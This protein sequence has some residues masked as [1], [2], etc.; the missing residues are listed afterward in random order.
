MTDD[1]L[2]IECKKGLTL[3][4]EPNEVIDRTIKQKLLAVKMYMKGAGVSDEKIVSDLGVG[5]LVMGVTD[6]WELKSGEVK[7]SP[8]FFTLVSQLALG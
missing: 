1:V 5:A 7:F 8:V 6:L 4:L 2:V 3:S